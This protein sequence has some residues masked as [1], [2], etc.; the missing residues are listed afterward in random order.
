MADLDRLRRLAATYLSARPDCA[1]FLQA[2]DGGRSAAGAATAVRRACAAAAPLDAA[3][4]RSSWATRP[5]VEA[6]LATT[7]LDWWTAY[8]PE[9]PAGRGMAV[10]SAISLLTGPGAPFSPRHGKA[11]F[12]LLGEGVEYA[13]HR[14]RPDEVYALL[15]GR[16]R[17]WLEGAGWREAAAGD[18]VQ[19]P[20]GRWHAAETRESPVLAL[21]AWIGEPLDRRPEFRDGSA[22]LPA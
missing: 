18:V 3:L 6:L 5:L 22:A 16:G 19:M 4:D 2:L 14:H 1:P 15:A 12:L 20:S 9:A 7:D 21:W 11:G 13:P 10:R 17:F 8:A